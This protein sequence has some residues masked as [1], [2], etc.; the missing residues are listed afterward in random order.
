MMNIVVNSIDEFIRFKFED[1]PFGEIAI[2]TLITDIFKTS[3]YDFEQVIQ[4]ANK[5][6]K[7]YYKPTSPSKKS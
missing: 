7:I 5:N 3:Y 4:F 2:A 1:V 6:K